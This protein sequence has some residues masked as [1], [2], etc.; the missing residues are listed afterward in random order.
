MTRP[1]RKLAA[2]FDD[3]R[4]AQ[5]ADLALVL[6]LLIMLIFGILWFGR[7]FNIYTTVNRAT[8][9]AAEAAAARSCATCGNS[10]QADNDIK[11]NVVDPIFV[12]SHLDPTQI[13]GFDIQHG[14]VVNPSSSPPVP[15]SVVTMTYPFN[16][17]L[18]G[19]TCCPPALTPITLGVNIHA[20]ANAREEN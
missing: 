12:A 16:F 10:F 4:G 3:D 2:F 15:S 19:L 1:T 11:T 14:I 20:T 6:P 9:E 17:K 5:I 7:A 8:H 18:N 13:A